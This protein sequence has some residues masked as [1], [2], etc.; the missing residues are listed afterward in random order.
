MNALVGR[1]VTPADHRALADYFQTFA[2]RYQAEADGHVGM[3]TLYRT[4]SRLAPVA[5][6][7]DRLVKELRDAA[8][9]A[10]QA[11]TMHG[12]LA[13]A[14]LTLTVPRLRDQ[15]ALNAQRL[16]PAS[17]S[18][19][20]MPGAPHRVGL[21]FVQLDDARIVGGRLG[22]LRDHAIDEGVLRLQPSV[23]PGR[24]VAQARRDRLP[25]E[26]DRRAGVPG[27]DDRAGGRA[28]SA[29]SEAWSRAARRR[30]PSA[31]A[32]RS[33]RPTLSVNS[34]SPV[35]AAAPSSTSVVLS[36]VWPG[37][38]RA[39]SDAPPTAMTAPSASGVNAKCTRRCSGSH[40][41]APDAAAS[42]RARDR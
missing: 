36:S 3:A 20:S 39:A 30:V 18:M 42:A 9:E 12:L 7:C 16:A 37:V 14:E 23:E 24:H 41:V 19:G 8:A 40:S 31:S 11:A 10:T 34:V 21:A 26:G 2:K 32:L 22:Q 35:N 6:H 4:T 25:V 33:G 17:S 27:Q 28:A 29:R 13:Q 1:A 38:R 15:C 5:N